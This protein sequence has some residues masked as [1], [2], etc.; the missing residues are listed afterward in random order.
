MP[1]LSDDTLKHLTE[2]SPHGWVVRG[3][4]SAPSATTLDADIATISGAT[5]KVIR[6]IGPPDWLLSVDF[7]SGHDS[8][9]KLPDLLLYNS[10]LFRRHRLLVRSLLVVF[11]A[12]VNN[13]NFYDFEVCQDGSYYLALYSNGNG[14]YVIQPKN[15][16]SIKTGLNQDNIV[17]VVAQGKSI[18]LYINNQNLSTAT[19]SSFSSG[20]VG[21]V[22][23]AVNG[24][25]DV[26]YAFA[27]VWTL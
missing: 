1:G 17:A 5:D 23:D 11:R 15:S 7:Q 12:D 19:D 8:L 20:S 2:L 14:K 26:A 13:N 25:T 27:K 9:A 10:A 18:T 3:G 4:W 24:S 21:L 16:S 6:A 22:G